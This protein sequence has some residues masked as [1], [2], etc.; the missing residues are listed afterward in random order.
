[1][2]LRTLVKKIKR[3]VAL[4]NSRS[5]IA[6][7]KKQGIRIG[8]GTRFQSPKT[9]TIDCTRP[10]LVS[11][12][13]NVFLH[14]G[15]T[16]M[17]HDFASSVIVKDKSL[18]YPSHGKISIG[19][20]VWFGQNCTILKGV[21]IGD[22]CIIGY[23]SIVLKDIPA[24]SVAAG[25]PARVICS[26]DEYV[27]KRSKVYIE[28][29]IEYAVEIIKSGREPQKEDF[30]D[31]YPC[32]VDAENCKDYDFP[33]SRIFKTEESFEQWK[34]RH[35]KRFNGFDDFISYVKSTLQY[36]QIGDE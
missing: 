4:R 22:N 35:H 9:A 18:F 25:C 7:Y 21:T 3:R 32:F 5:A 24:N 19:N 36:R 1:M 11:I 8:K 29:A 30:W 2:S 10:E 28:E 16:I 13:D 31:D 12:G 34:N 15:I 14:K 23:G 6:Y 33:Y 26:L 17:T 27:E 20:N